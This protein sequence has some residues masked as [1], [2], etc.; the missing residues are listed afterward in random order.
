MSPTIRDIALECGVTTATVSLALQNN[1]RISDKRKKEILSVAKHI[2]YQPNA[3]AKS[4]RGGKTNS[5]G[6]LWSLGAAKSIHIVREIT[7]RMMELGYVSY[8][9]DSL[10]DPKIIKSCLQDYVAR[11]IDGL[12]IFDPAERLHYP[13]I[14]TN[15]KK[16]SNVVIVSRT[17]VSE[18]FPFDFIIDSRR[19]AMQKII[20]HLLATGRKKICLVA[21]A[22]TAERE[23]GFKNLLAENGILTDDYRLYNSG[24][25]YS[26]SANVISRLKADPRAY[27]AIMTGN[28][29]TAAAVIN[30]LVNECGVRV[31]EDV[32]VI[33]AE[34]SL[35]SKHFHIPIA[36]TRI[37]AQK[38]ATL[39]VEM[40][41]EQLEKK[42]NS[43]RIETLV[44]EFVMRRSGGEVARA[45]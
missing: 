7:F 32:A 44:Q 40:L 18:G 10:G 25:A 36:T 1:S 28:D 8:I 16:I 9:A 14:L 24:D 42:R 45:P 27:D 6:I 33:G 26:I 20:D 12:I 11:N 43:P 4:L 41:M 37:C 23:A 29:E 2:G 31:P 22:Y 19:L 21:N 17:G 3:I 5:I 35:M 30:C 39:T 15:L 38:F 13:E 34:E